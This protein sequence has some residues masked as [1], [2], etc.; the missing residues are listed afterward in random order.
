MSIKIEIL[1]YKY[2]SDDN[3]ADVNQ[4][5]SGLSYGWTAVANTNA[6][7]DGS[8]SGITFLNNIDRDWET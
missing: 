3:M 8:G 6:S 1:D 7:W 4:A 5:S 2:G